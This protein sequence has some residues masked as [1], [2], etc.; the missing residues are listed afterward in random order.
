METAAKI[1]AIEASGFH[2]AY[3]GCHKIYV[4]ET[5]SDRSE[6]RD[7][8]YDDADIFPAS[9]IRRLINQ[10]CFLVF[11]QSLRPDFPWDIE[12]GEIFDAFGEAD[13]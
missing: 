2:L 12:Q 9:Q 11:V 7:S 5:S 13:V 10:S 6:M 8:G 3:D 1:D 4:I